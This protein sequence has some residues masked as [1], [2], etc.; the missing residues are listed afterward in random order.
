MTIVSTA[1]TGFLVGGSLIVAI[2]PQNAFVLRMGLLRRHVLPLVL[3]CA[4]SDALLIL[5][6][7]LGLG[8]V[9]SAHRQA[10]DAIAIGG[11]LFLLWYGWKSLRRALHPAGLDQAASQSVSLRRSLLTCAAFTWGNPHVYLD[12]VLLI[13][14]LSLPYHGLERAAYSGGAM[15]ASYAWFGAL[16]YGA[17]FLVPLFRRPAT[18]RFLDLSIA[19]V[20]W[21]IA[22]RLIY[23]T[24][25][26]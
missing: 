26:R 6:G 10:A 11:A 2:G 15:A 22:L 12:T 8:A 19:L 3:F 16:G 20:M 14:S 1:L 24:L 5:A 25:F 17:G 4:T 7:V 18:W 21:A 13:G 9:L 23:S